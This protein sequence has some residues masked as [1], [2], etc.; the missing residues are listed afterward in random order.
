MCAENTAFK[1]CCFIGHREIEETEE[2]R[3]AVR[4]LVELLI[5]EQGVDTFLFGSR[6]QFNSLCYELVSEIKIKSPH[7]RRVYVRAEFEH[8]SDSYKAYLLRDYEDTYFPEKVKGA[9]RASYIKRNFEMI[10]ESEF[11]VFCFD[12]S[13]TRKGKSGT[14]IAL[15]YA[16]K[17][18]RRIF[19]IL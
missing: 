6:S 9:G 10:D 11:C 1:T 7:I 5:S 12:E 18:G 17:R 4:E 8:I 2:L 3:E 16:R 19:N 15:D 14:K 13:K